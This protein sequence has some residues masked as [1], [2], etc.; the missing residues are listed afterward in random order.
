MI[1]Y[2]VSMNSTDGPFF[3]YFRGLE[4]ADLY[5]EHFS[6]MRADSAFIYQL[7]E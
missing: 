4:M 7:Y 1:Q 5:R 3:D 6:P 2:V